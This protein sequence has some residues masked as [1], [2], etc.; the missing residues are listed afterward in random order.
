MAW[1]ELSSF[2]DG[3]T[4]SGG[5]KCDQPLEVGEDKEMDS[6]LEHLGRKMQ[7]C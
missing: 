7:P 6:P 5:K 3:E 1:E 4:R 2:D